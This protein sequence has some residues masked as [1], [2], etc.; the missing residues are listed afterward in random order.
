MF[1]F[2][3]QR[4]SEAMARTIDL[5]RKC[6][7][8]PGKISPKVGAAY[9]DENGILISEAYRGEDG[10][11]DHAEF[12][13]LEKKLKDVDVSQGTLLTTLEPCTIRSENKTPCCSRIIERGVKT[14]YIGTL[15]PNSTIRGDGELQLQEAGIEVRRYNQGMADEIRKICADFWHKYRLPKNV[16]PEP[17]LK[18]LKG[19]NGY[20]LG[21]MGDGDLVEWIPDEEIEG[22]FFPMIV[23]RSDSQI[24]DLYNELWDKVWWNRHMYWRGQ[25]ESGES[26]L[27]ANEH[28]IMER[29]MAAAKRIEDRFGI[30]NLGWNDVDWGILQGKMS[31]LAW[32]M[33]SEWDG[34]MD[35]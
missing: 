30:E 18:D 26:R 17:D 13:L 1:Y 34:S 2:D 25:I 29:A 10:V 35:T 20:S 11:G 12:I 4:E 32:V 27:T 7:S 23:R 24:H 3:G 16:I 6:V 21:Y 5:S 15:D 8:E 28:P 22:E 31:A 9:L 19:P 33:G 14:V